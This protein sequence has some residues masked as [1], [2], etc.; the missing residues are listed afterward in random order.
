MKRIALSVAIAGLASAPALA[1]DQV[2]QGN[3]TLFLS[4]DVSSQLAGCDLR[5]FKPGSSLVKGDRVKLRANTGVVSRDSDKP[6]LAEVTHIGGLSIRCADSGRV[7][8]SNLRLDAIDGIPTLSA[9]VEING[10]LQG[11]QVVATAAPAAALGWESSGSAFLLLKQERFMLT[12]EGARAFNALVNVG[13]SYTL[14]NVTTRVRLRE[15]SADDDAWY[16]DDYWSGSDD[17]RYIDPSDLPQNIREFIE[18]NY[19]SQFITLVEVEDDDDE[20][21]KYEVYLNNGF[22]LY[23][24]EFGN[25]VDIDTD[26]DDSG[27]DDD[28]WSGSG[29]DSGSDDDDSWSG[30]DDDQ[31][32]DS[33]QLPDNILA[34]I[35]A[36]YPG[37]TITLV[38]VEDDDDEEY[39]YE[40]TLSNGVELYFDAFGNLVDVDDD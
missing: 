19:P 15:Q 24:D 20:E 22:E 3:T 8:L 18:E 30:S 35:A 6:I 38:E 27:S 36:N 1:V 31:I 25:L 10:W 40:V 28:S 17:D 32:I 16:D 11:R 2:K 13:P 21:Y 5:A 23:F 4:D 37:L 33:S 9:V 39:K 12:E 34:Y 26:D 29:D 7:N 14:G